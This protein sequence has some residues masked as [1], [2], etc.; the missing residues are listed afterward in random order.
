MWQSRQAT[1]CEL[2]AKNV[3]TPIP[4]YHVPYH[5]FQPSNP[6]LHPHTE[7]EMTAIACQRQS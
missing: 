6:D 4:H 5:L 3:Q 1:E 2:A 7:S